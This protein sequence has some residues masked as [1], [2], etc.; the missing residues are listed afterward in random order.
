MEPAI[1]LPEAIQIEAV[2][3]AQQ[4]GIS[5]ND[6]CTDAII[7]Y[8]R[9]HNR[10]AILDQLNKVY[11]AQPSALDPTIAKLQYASLPHEDW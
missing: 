3:L 1:L 6:L 5:V 7:I 10:Q 9:K 2:V 4:L 8:L 11:P